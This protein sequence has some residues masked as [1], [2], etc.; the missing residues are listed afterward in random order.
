MEKCQSTM[1]HCENINI[2]IKSYFHFIPIQKCPIQPNYPIILKSG[3]LVDGWISRQLCYNSPCTVPS[4]EHWVYVQ[5]CV[6]RVHSTQYAYYIV[7]Q[8]ECTKLLFWE[9]LTILLHEVGKDLSWPSITFINIRR[10][11]V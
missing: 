5:S 6:V 9:S 1:K 7:I 4:W 11:Y 3:Q 8:N 10:V 2:C